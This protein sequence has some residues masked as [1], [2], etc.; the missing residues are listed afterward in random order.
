MWDTIRHLV[1]SGSTVLLTTQYLEE[2][3]QL[4]DRIAVIDRGKVVAEGAPNELK[5][6]VGVAS[7][8]LK[9]E[10]SADVAAAENVVQVILHAETQRPEPT[11]ITAPMAHPD[12]VTD[13]LVALRSQN[14]ALAEVSVQKPTLDEVFLALTGH[15][16]ESNA[17]KGEKND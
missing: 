3:D 10:K 11:L 13:L 4:A 6:S 1:A 7:L 9:V 14:L 8:Q 12:K 2:A 16:T 5:N 17:T 15:T